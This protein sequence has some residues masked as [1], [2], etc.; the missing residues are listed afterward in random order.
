MKKWMLALGGATALAV[1]AKANERAWVGPMVR[2]WFYCDAK[3][4][5]LHWKAGRAQGDGVRIWED[6]ESLAVACSEG[7]EPFVMHGIADGNGIRWCLGIVPPY[8]TAATAYRFGVEFYK[9]SVAVGHGAYP[10]GF[11]RDTDNQCAL[12]F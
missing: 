10:E 6:G 1:S 4:R 5:L 7:R 8:V 12:V 3:D 9:V 11:K 2:D